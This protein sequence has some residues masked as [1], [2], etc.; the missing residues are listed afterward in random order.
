MTTYYDEAYF[1]WQK[2]IGEFGGK[3]NLF[4]FQ[5]YIQPTD[6]VLDFGCGGG[7]LLDQLDVTE[8]AGLEIN[9]SAVEVARSYG[10]TVYTALSDIPDAYADV[11]ISNHTLEHVDNPLGTLQGLLPKV[12]RQGRVVFVVPHQK[13]SE[14]WHPDNVSQHLYTWNPMTLGNLFSHAGFVDIQADAI[15]HTWSPQYQRIHK[16]LGEDAFH[17]A[18]RLWSRLTSTAQIRVVCKRP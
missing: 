18:S 16:Y 7:Y 1:A 3:A 6:T 13:P 8:K 15:W 12:K 2:R 14:S 9:E 5:P 17:F 10:L 4:K 11:V